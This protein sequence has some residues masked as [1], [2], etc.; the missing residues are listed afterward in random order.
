LQR[1]GAR[2]S[3]APRAL[4]LGFVAAAWIGVGKVF[5]NL[6]LLC[7]CP[8]HTSYTR[9]RVCAADRPRPPSELLRTPLLGRTVNKGEREDRDDKPRSFPLGGCANRRVAYVSRSSA[10]AV[11]EKS[12]AGV[13]SRMIGTDAR[14]DAG[15]R[16]S[17][18]RALWALR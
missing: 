11:L 10:E 7:S 4:S 14:H 17:T 3:H 9:G 1:V 16:R 18:G 15:H 6:L 5:P 12:P 8:E 2:T 13:D